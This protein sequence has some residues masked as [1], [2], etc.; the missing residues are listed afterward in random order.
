MSKTSMSNVATALEVAAIKY[1]NNKDDI[2][3]LEKVNKGIATTILEY[4]DDLKTKS[5]S[6]ITGD[7]EGDKNAKYTFTKAERNKVSYDIAKVKEAIDKK[8][9]NKIVD[10]EFI[11]DYSKLVD[12]AKK[13]KISKEEIM[14]C[15]TV[16]ESIDNKKVNELFNVGEI[17]INKLKGTFTIDT[18]YYLTV[19]KS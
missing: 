11:A 7:S 6:F 19:R 13:Y 17:D 12:L 2:E 10:R 8:T 3:K 16:N 4:L 15:I 1:L 14:E 5:Y 9:F 18:N